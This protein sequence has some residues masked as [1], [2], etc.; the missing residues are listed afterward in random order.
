M[1]V[2]TGNGRYTV[3][4]REPEAHIPPPM[5]TLYFDPRTGERVDERP[6]P[7]AESRRKPPKHVISHFTEE[8]MKKAQ[9]SIV[10]NCGRAVL[11]DGERYASISKGAAALGTKPNNLGAALRSGRSEYKGHAVAFA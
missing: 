11:V 6:E 10:K 1:E 2:I 9:A 7:L 3:P 8:D 4:R 5:V